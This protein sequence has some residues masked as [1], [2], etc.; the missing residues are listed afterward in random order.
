MTVNEEIVAALRARSTLELA[1]I[2]LEEGDSG[3]V[4]DFLKL[5]AIPMSLL[6]EEG[7]RRAGKSIG[8]PEDFIGFLLDANCTLISSIDRIYLQHA[9][10]AKA[11]EK[12]F[13][14]GRRA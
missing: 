7:A 12:K 11:V 14:D 4:N 13:L 5:G 8:S 10:R 9:S 2:I 1:V 6:L 3:V